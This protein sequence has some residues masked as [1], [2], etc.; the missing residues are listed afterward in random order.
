[1]SIVQQ[2]S[3]ENKNIIT[4]QNNSGQD[5][6]VIRSP[7]MV[8]RMS[9]F[10]ISPFN[11][12]FAIPF[13]F[14]FFGV[15]INNNLFLWACKTGNQDL[16]AQL[17]KDSPNVNLKSSY[18]SI[19]YACRDG[20]TE[21]VTKI[22]DSSHY[23]DIDIQDI[24]DGFSPLHCACIDGNVDLVKLLI[25]RKANIDIKDKGER[26]P[27]HWACIKGNKEI[28]Q[29]LIAEDPE[30]TEDAQKMTPIQWANQEVIDLF[31]ENGINQELVVASNQNGLK[32]PVSFWEG[33]TKKA[34]PVQ[35]LTQNLALKIINPLLLLPFQLGIFSA[36]IGYNPLH[37]ACHCGNVGLAEQ[38]LHMEADPHVRTD[39]GY[40]PLHIACIREKTDIVKLFLQHASKSSLINIKD[41]EEGFSPLH[42]ACFRGN[43]EIVNLLIQMGGDIEAKDRHGF[44]PFHWACINGH[45]GVAEQLIGKGAN[46]HAVNNDG[47]TALDWANYKNRTALI[48]LLKSKGVKEIYN[49]NKQFGR[50]Y[51]NITMF[52]QYN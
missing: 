13:K 51:C 29:L 50:T 33:Y 12:L 19:H 45:K 26:T 42:W 20:N 2:V 38:L 43:T 41:F 1:M 25:A 23:A 44:T 6:S 46:I 31:K 40:T 5:T 47:E 28:V 21:L 10:V 7:S 22:L 48:E 35:N 15:N 3:S 8:G 18:A 24:F 30:I 27:L 37:W 17:L 49:L 32:P 16:I 14:G 52:S 9:T 34:K 11:F 4:N 36:N 39:C